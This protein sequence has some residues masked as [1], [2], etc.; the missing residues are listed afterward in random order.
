MKI[1]KKPNNF[2]LDCDFEVRKEEEEEEFNWK[3]LQVR[4]SFAKKFTCCFSFKSE[5]NLEK[6]NLVK[7]KKKFFWNNLEEKQT[8]V[9][10]EK[11]QT[12]TTSERQMNVQV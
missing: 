11:R 2:E 9:N 10:D 5:N 6:L 12:H 3:S 1:K 7:E 4:N 8:K